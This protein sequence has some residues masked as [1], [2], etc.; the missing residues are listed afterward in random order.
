VPE[1]LL[2]E[3]VLRQRSLELED[4]V[5]VRWIDEQTAVLSADTT[6]AGAGVGDGGSLHGELG[7]GTV[8]GAF[9]DSDFAVGWCHDGWYFVWIVVER[10]DGRSTCISCCCAATLGRGAHPATTG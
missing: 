2:T 6:I 5:F 7:S 1:G 9:V 10:E 4:E 3:S 8:A